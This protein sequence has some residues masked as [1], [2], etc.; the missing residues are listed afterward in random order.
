MHRKGTP[1]MPTEPRIP[2]T[3]PPEYEDWGHSPIGG[4]WHDGT[5][6]PLWW[7]ILGLITTIIL[8]LSVV[9]IPLWWGLNR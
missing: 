6:G 2:R 3:D 4:G 7:Q 1:T 5:D 9:L 8:G